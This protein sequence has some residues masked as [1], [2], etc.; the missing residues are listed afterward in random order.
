MEFIITEYIYIYIYMI[1]LP[2]A[3]EISD[4]DDYPCINASALEIHVGAGHH[5]SH[6][7]RHWHFH[8]CHHHPRH[9]HHHHGQG[10]GDHHRHRD[11]IVINYTRN[12]YKNNCNSSRIYSGVTV[13][14]RSNSHVSL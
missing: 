4:C 14:T 1:F 3:T 9:L 11:V 13:A 12:H 10:H 5:Y 2:N 7:H 6:H 8:L